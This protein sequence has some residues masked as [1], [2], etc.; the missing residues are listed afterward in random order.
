VI[1]DYR[2]CC[3]STR[4]VCEPN[5]NVADAK[6]PLSPDLEGW[7]LQFVTTAMVGRFDHPTTLLAEPF[8]QRICVDHRVV[9]QLVSFSARSGRLRVSD[10][11]TVLLDRLCQAPPF[12]PRDR[13]SRGKFSRSQEL[14]P[15]IQAFRSKTFNCFRVSCTVRRRFDEF[16]FDPPIDLPKKIEIASELSKPVLVRIE[17]EWATH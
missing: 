1:Q 10:W 17:H 6:S 12:G 11:P 8:R 14:R 3:S 16:L 5:P 13:A 7:K 9:R 2:S 15:F 4:Q